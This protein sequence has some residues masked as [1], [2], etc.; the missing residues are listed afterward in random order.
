MYVRT[1]DLQNE[2]SVFGA[3]L[4]CH[5]LCIK[6]YLLKYDRAKAKPVENQPMNPKESAWLSVMPEI[7]TGLIQGD[8]YELSYV[9]DCINSKLGS[10]ICVNN[11]EVKVLL[12]NYFGSK[13]SFSKPKQVNKSQMFFSS[14]VKAENLA[15]TIRS[16][17]PIRQCAEMIRQCL[18]ELDFDLQDRFCDVNDLETATANMVIPE[19]ILKFFATLYN[20]DMNS[21]ENTSKRLMKGAADVVGDE[22]DC[23][24]RV[25][26]AKCRQV[27]GLTQTLYYIL[28]RGR[29]RTPMHIMNSQAIYDACKSAT[30]ITSFNRYGLCS[31]YDELLRHHTDMATFIVES[32]SNEVPFPSHFGSS[33]FTIAAFDNFDHDEA[34]LSG[35]GGSHDTV[36]VLFQDDDGSRIGKPKV[37]ETRTK[38]GQKTFKCELECQELQTFRKPA[39]KADLPID[40]NVETHPVNQDLLDE[41]RT[42][43]LA[44]SL[45]RIDLSEQQDTVNIRPTEQSM[46]SWRETNTVLS[47]TNIPRKRVGFLPVLPYPVTQ[48]DTVYTALKNFHGILQHLDQPKLPVTCDE[49][50]YHIAREIQLIRPEEFQDLVLCMGSF[51][52]AKVALGCLG[53]YLKGSGAESILVESGIF[54]VNVVESILTG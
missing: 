30:L 21:F 5:N 17:D 26:E 44:W 12:T 4:Y 46:P 6:N 23:G 38:H 36:S 11:R 14:T 43:D 25:S 42:K 40:Y 41:V 54:G 10:D 19:P 34:T 31:S 35:I 7:E 2:H 3:D 13:I 37:S 20:F 18:L 9:R 45:A 24:T 1:C 51:H 49:G 22:S 15:E 8:G 16:T 27:Q 29:K 32:S 52:M 39:K 53:K 48:Y 28:H 47:M 33:Q 50:V